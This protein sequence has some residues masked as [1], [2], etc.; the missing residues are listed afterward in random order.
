[1]HSIRPCLWCTDN[2]QEIADFYTS[3]FKDSRVLDRSY[4]GAAGPMPE[5]TLLTAII[6]LAGQEFTLL[7]GG[8]N[9]EVKFSDAISFAVTVDTQADVDDLWDQ[10]TAGGTPGPCGWLKDKFGVSWQI[11]PAGLL[12]MVT[13]Q[14]SEKSTRTMKAMMTMGKLDVA[15]LQRAHAGETVRP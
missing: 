2:A 5:G 11:V 3:T 13:D 12:E 7:N 10:L 1:M 15:E 14:D 8:E 6:E 9:P 4:Y